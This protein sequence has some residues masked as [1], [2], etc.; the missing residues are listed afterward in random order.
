VAAP[1]LCTGWFSSRI[2]AE[3]VARSQLKESTTMS[4]LRLTAER[5][6]EFGKGS[7]RRTRRAGKIPAVL[8]GHGADPQHLALPGREF[9]LAVK[10]AG[11]NV[12]LTLEIEGTDALAIPKAI[13]RNPLKGTFDHV[14]LISVRQGEKINVDVPILLEGE[15]ASGALLQQESNSISVEADATNIPTE[16]TLSVEGLTPGTQITAADLVLPAGV[17]LAGD[18]EE[19]IIVVSEAP[20]AEQLDAEAEASEAGPDPVVSQTESAE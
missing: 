9:T 8:Y 4:E 5:R 20:T 17:S 12:L 14:D 16:L 3:Y 2:R 7:A 10:R 1:R 18:P 19:L 15:I 11:A 13:Q 6:T